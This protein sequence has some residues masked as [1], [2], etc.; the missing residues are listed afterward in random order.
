MRMSGRA[1]TRV[2]RRRPSPATV[3][4]GLALFISLGG[5]SYAVTQLPPNSVGTAQVRD[6]SL[7]KQDFKASVL[8]R[9]ERGLQGKTGATGPQGAKGDTGAQGPTGP[10]GAT[11]PTGPRGATGDT[12]A[13]G[14][15]G[16][17]G[18][19]FGYEAIRADEATTVAVGEY[20]DVTISTTE[21][22]WG[23]VSGGV[24]IVGED[25]AKLVTT[26]AFPVADGSG[27]KMTVYNSGDA[28]ATFYAWAFF[29]PDAS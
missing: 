19:S 29:A 2:V 22:G 12:G 16:A 5:T 21:E 25:V 9:G 1:W 8:L 11:G 27:W 17:A 10:T 18:A 15:R 20:K 13:T 6:H 14:A 3:L 7:L 26:Q 4:A 24:E 28:T 23:A